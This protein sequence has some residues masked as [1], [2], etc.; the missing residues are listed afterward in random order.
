MGVDLHVA[1]R[2]SGRACQWMQFGR[3]LAAVLLARDFHRRPSSI[4]VEGHPAD[5]ARLIAVSA[6]LAFAGAPDL[7]LHLLQHTLDGVF[8]RQ[9]EHRTLR[10]RRRKGPGHGERLRRGEGQVDIADPGFGGVHGSLPIAIGQFRVVCAPPAPDM[11]A[12]FSCDFLRGYA[13]S[14]C[15]PGH[16]ARGLIIGQDVTIGAPASKHVSELHAIGASVALEAEDFPKGR[17]AAWTSLPSIPLPSAR[18]PLRR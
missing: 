12:V 5:I 13:H 9:V 14:A 10:L 2:P 7:R 15:E 18:W 11:R 3:E 4:V 1:G 17:V 6:S 16:G 8:V